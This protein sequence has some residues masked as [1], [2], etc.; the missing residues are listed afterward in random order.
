M[1]M[2]K[3]PECGNLVEESLKECNIC[4]YPFDGTEE[5]VESNDDD[6]NEKDI[7]ISM[8]KACKKE[9]EKERVVNEENGDEVKK[10]FSK[11]KLVLFGTIIGIAILG[12][13]IYKTSDLG[14]YNSAQSAYKNKRYAEAMEEFKS[15]EKYKDSEKMYKKAKHMVAVSKDDVAPDLENIQNSIEI[16][17]G[18][19][20]DGVNWCKENGV[21]VFDNVTQDIKYSVDDSKVNTSQAGTYDFVLSAEDEAGNKQEKII[22]VLVKRIYTQEEISDAVKSTYTKEIPGLQ[23]IEYDKEAKTVWVFVSFDGMSEVAIGAKINASLK[24]QWDSLGDELDNVSGTIYYHLIAEGY[25]D[26]NSV[27]VTLL[28]EKNIDKMLYTAIN[29]TEFFDVTD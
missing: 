6:Y 27:C 18:E 1:G 10:T 4:G 15:L 3:C 2:R 26:I 19:E 23:R 13:V 22:K 9:E 16:I 7:E 8:E 12:F 29:G 17:M 5:L 25:T 14:H 20:F 11:K 21:T 24:S 28:N